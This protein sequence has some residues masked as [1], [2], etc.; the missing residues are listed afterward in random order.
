MNLSLPVLLLILALIAFILAA[1]GWSYRKT[2]LVAIGLGLL[3]LSFLIARLSHLSPGTLILLLAFLAFVGA[4][5]GWRYR[6]INLIATG[7]ALF[8]LSYVVA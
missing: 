4:A 6:K 1:I 3:S 7:L 8:T 2:D 5:V